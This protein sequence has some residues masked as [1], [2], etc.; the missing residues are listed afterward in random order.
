MVSRVLHSK[1][2]ISKELTYKIRSN[3]DISTRSKVVMLLN[4]T[5]GAMNN[6]P[7]ARDVLDELYD[8][9]KECDSAGQQAVVAIRI[10]SLSDLST[11]GKL[12][13]FIV[14]TFGMMWLV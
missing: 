5:V 12:Q 3:D 10:M 14:Y 6:A 7:R 11:A 13:I 8:V 4:E 9:F 1:G 2:V